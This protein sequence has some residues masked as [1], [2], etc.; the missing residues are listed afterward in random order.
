MSRKNKLAI[1]KNMPKN[2]VIGTTIEF[3]YDETT[4]R[5]NLAQE[6]QVEKQS[7]Q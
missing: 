6:Y 2:K 7:I 4:E 1:E 5:R 3:I